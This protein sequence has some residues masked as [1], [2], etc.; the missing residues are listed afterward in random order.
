MAAELDLNRIKILGAECTVGV[1]LGFQGM[2]T[3][4]RNALAK[5]VMD[6]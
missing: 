1:G 3:I 6:R 4:N 2:L 5:V